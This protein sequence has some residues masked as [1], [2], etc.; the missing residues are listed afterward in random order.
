MLVWAT[1]FPLSRRRG[2]DD[3][4]RV[5]KSTLAS[6]PHTPWQG[7]SFGDDPTNDLKQLDLEDQVVTIGCATSTNERIA[8]LR[9]VWIEDAEREWATEAVGYEG[10]DGTIVSV[11]LDCNILRP[12]LPLR[13]PKKP[14]VVRRLLEDLGG[15]NDGGLVVQDS[16]HELAEVD[17]DVAASLVLGRT[18]VRLPVVYVSVGR[19]RRPLVDVLELAQWL[20]GMAHVVVEPSRYFS[21]ALARNTGRMNAYGGAVSIYWPSASASQ[22]RFLPHAFDGPDPMQSEIAARVGLALTQVRPESRCTFQ[23][24]RELSSHAQIERLRAAGSTAVDKYAAAFD[25]EITAK[26]QRL[27]D[28]GRELA[29]VNGEL[30][31]YE[32]VAEIGKGIIAAGSEREFYPGEIRDALITTLGHGRRNLVADGRY[33]H[34]VDDVLNANS[35]TGT[36]NEVGTEIKE[37]FS[38]S[39]DLGQSQRQVLRDLGF[40]IEEA[41]KHWKVTYQGDQRYKFVISKTSSDHRAGKNLV[42]TIV[43]KLLK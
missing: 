40:D 42:S 3:V 22:V 9:H 37:A 23:Y 31:R 14:Y 19:S 33:Q 8:G 26:D 18:A 5:A 6:S 12:G 29:R 25:S 24:L 15:G 4:L 11:R 21:F 27:A 28:M 10:G 7:T 43:K 35:L 36:G 17:V 34:L 16:P 2:C 1:E 20:G 30:R 39:G 38:S 13:A 32:E 41:G